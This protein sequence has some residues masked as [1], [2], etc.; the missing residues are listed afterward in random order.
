METSLKEMVDKV[1]MLQ[2]RVVKMMDDESGDVHGGERTAT[3]TKA[4]IDAET[5]SKID[6]IEGKM[7]KVLS[8]FSR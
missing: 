6:A 7:A 1:D 4:K 5:I 2:K 3:S 8:M